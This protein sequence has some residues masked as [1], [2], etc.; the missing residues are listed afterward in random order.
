MTKDEWKEW[1]FQKAHNTIYAIDK[2]VPSAAILLAEKCEEMEQ[3]IKDMRDR[4]RQESNINKIALDI[5]DY[6]SQITETNHE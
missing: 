2:S 4:L 6:L 3:E 1:A 5:D